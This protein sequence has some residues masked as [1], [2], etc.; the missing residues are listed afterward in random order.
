ME[1]RVTLINKGFIKLKLKVKIN[2]ENF[3]RG[4]KSYLSSK[5]YN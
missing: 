3:K 5:Y 2:P 4:G 1:Q